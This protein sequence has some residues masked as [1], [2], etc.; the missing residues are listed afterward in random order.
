MLIHVFKTIGRWDYWSRSPFICCHRVCSRPGDTQAS[1]CFVDR[2]PADKQRLREVKVPCLNLPAQ[3][4]WVRSLRT[5]LWFL[6][7]VKLLSAKSRFWMHQHYTSRTTTWDTNLIIASK[8]EMTTT[9]ITLD[10]GSKYRTQRFVN[11]GRVE[12][13][14]ILGIHNVWKW[15]CR[16]K[17]TTRTD[18]DP[19]LRKAVPRCFMP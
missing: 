8:S 18:Q 9:I 19:L 6:P 10:A 16:I 11:Y 2:F 5:L 14:K 12:F 1:P 3:N 4:W 15:T 17:R 13:D 7:T